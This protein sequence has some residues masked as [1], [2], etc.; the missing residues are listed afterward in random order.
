MLSDLRGSSDLKEAVHSNFKG[1]STPS[2]V[3]FAWWSD[4]LLRQ[5]KGYCSSQE[6]YQLGIKI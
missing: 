1:A 4:A 6:I 2:L 5:E 3:K